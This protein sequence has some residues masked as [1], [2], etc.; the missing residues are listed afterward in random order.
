MAHDSTGGTEAKGSSVSTVPERWAP[1]VEGWRRRGAAVAGET[2][3]QLA[4]RAW[5]EA[6]RAARLLVD[7]FGVTRVVVFGSLAR[8]R[9]REG[10]DIDLAV[11]GLPASHFIR[12][13]ARLAWE[14]SLPLDL[15]P[16]DECSPLLRRHIDEDGIELA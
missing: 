6:R 10:S 11:E 9:F 8:G 13:D 7:E 3:R 4:E 1:Y 2:D 16:L 12:A 5:E 14:L 15:K